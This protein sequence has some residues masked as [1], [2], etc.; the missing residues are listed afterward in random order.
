[1]KRFLMFFIKE[2]APIFKLIKKLEK[3]Y[4]TFDS[5]SSSNV[6]IEIIAIEK[7]IVKS[8][9]IISYF[10]SQINNNN[11]ITLM[12]NQQTKIP[13]YLWYTNNGF[14]L[15]NNDKLKEFILISK[16][17]LEIYYDNI[18]E[19]ENLTLERNIRILTSTIKRIEKTLETIDTILV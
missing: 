9:S 8:I 4:T 14:N 16:E 7:D 11:K 3:T 12:N 2:K 17:L 18:N 5:Y 1:M 6:N 19:I 13:L 10:I 15:P